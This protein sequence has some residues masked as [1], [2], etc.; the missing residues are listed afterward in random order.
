M[1]SISFLLFLGAAFG[2]LA[3]EESQDKQAAAD[4]GNSLDTLQLPAIAGLEPATFLRML[5]ARNLDLQYSQRNTEVTRHLSSAEAALY[6]PVSFMSVR[7]EG[8]DRQRSADELL[9]LNI[10]TPVL[11][12]L[13]NTNEI[14]VRSKAPTG[15]DV[16]LSYSIATR[17]NNLIPQNTTA[18]SEYTSALTLTLKQPLLRNAGRS[19][20][21]TDKRVAELEYSASVQQLIQQTFK[22]G[23]DGLNLYWQL[24]KSQETVKLRVKARATSKS[25]LTDAQARVT[26]GRMPENT[27][28]ELRGNLLNREVELLRSQQVLQESQSTLLT[29]LDVPWSSDLSASTAPQWSAAAPRPSAP[30]TL[31]EETLL[32]WS[33]YQVALIRQQQARIR[34]DYARNQMRPLLDLVMSYSG[35][36]LDYNRS[37][38]VDVTWRTRYPDWY[39]G[40]NLELPVGGNQKA[41]EQ[42]LAQNA[43]VDQS[44]LEVRAIRSS[45]SNDL[46]V[47]LADMHN[48]YAVIKLG[49]D[50]LKLRQ[51]TFDNERQRIQLGSG[52]LSNLI[53]KQADLIEASQRLLE[54]QVRYEIALATWQYTRGSLL[55]D[56]GIHIVNS[57]PSFN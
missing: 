29:A 33:P 23:I 46:S 26:A 28:L 18:V 38:A 51:S 12:E 25:L 3:A 9:R 43:R 44:E 20:T 13:V 45:F 16:S 41:T 48:A 15:A 11:Q 22:T 27:L 57:L 47:R 37:A 2:S 42:Y 55:I 24:H 35:T 7:R 21:E 34:L 17:T 36:G 5:V 56:N 49:T 1:R 39:I 19:I 10:S 31:V 32:L 50:E 53:Q 54:N 52:S 30:S 6:E 40:L 8:R 14:G 4:Q